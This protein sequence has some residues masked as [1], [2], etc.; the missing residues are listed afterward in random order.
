MPTNVIVFHYTLTDNTGKQIDSSAGSDPLAFIVGSGQIIAGLETHLLTM[1]VGEKRKVLV[2][3]KDAYGEVKATDIMEVPLAKLPAKKI[4]VGDRFRAGE[5]DHAPVV[6]VTKVTA[7]HATLDANH[8]LAGQNLTFDVEVTEVRAAT[9][10]ELSHGHVHGP[11][12]HHH[13]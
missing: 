13:H 9:K 4:K 2:P 11:G 10:E 1:K 8:E 12:G 6:R 5:G 3:A 7:T